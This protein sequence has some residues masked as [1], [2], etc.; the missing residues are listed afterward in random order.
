MM[1]QHS[2]STGY[3]VNLPGITTSWTRNRPEEWLG[4]QHLVLFQL[5]CVVPVADSTTQ[6][7]PRGRFRDAATKI[8]AGPPTA[9]IRSQAKR[10]TVKLKYLKFMNETK[11]TTTKNNQIYPC[12]VEMSEI[13][14]RAS[15]SCEAIPLNHDAV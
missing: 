1:C 4:E 3:T 11:K 6:G 13:I 8:A 2:P 7:R 15:K 5:F 10:T 12:R 14:K 9:G